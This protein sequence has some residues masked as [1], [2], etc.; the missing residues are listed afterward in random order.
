VEP[1][2][3]D[4]LFRASRAFANT[5]ESIGLFMLAVLFAIFVSAEPAWT[6]LG[7]MIYLVGRVGHMT[8]Y[9]LN[10]AL[11]RSLSFALSLLGVV[12]I[13]SAG[14]AHWF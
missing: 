5:N 3:Q 1:D 14:I 13:L 6:N 2:F 7:A 11:L 8:C 9:Y 4:I 12:I 10:K